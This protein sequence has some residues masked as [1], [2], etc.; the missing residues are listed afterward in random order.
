MDNNTEALV[1]AHMAA[2]LLNN[3]MYRNADA[4]TAA[5]IYYKVLNELRD[6]QPAGTA[7][8]AR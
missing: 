2:A 1:A 5:I 3:G 8:F 4:E 6:K 7:T